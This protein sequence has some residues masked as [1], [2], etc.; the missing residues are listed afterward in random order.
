MEGK[1]KNVFFNQVISINYS[2]ESILMNKTNA[3]FQLLL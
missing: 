3:V 1:I 2:A